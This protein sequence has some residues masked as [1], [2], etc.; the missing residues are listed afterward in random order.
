MIEMPGWMELFVIGVVALLVVGPKEL[1][2]LLRTLG[3]YAAMVKRQASEFRSQ[4]DEAIQDSDLQEV[5]KDMETWKDEASET[6]RDME[7]TVRNDMYDVQNEYDDLDDDL[8]G[9]T[10][11]DKAKT[12]AKATTHTQSDA[13]IGSTKD[14]SADVGASD[15][16]AGSAGGEGGNASEAAADE[17]RDADA[18]DDR[19]AAA[20]LARQREEER[21]A[22][23]SMP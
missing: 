12:T 11:R 5:R 7:Q 16:G 21:T 4:L 20:R 23:A 3:K 19:E 14:A 17:T 6:A 10:A 13:P 8:R 9:G 1:P 18:S 22:A 15:Q 2:G